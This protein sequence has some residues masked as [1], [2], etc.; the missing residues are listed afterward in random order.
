MEG[1]DPIK[2]SGGQITTCFVSRVNDWVL[3]PDITGTYWIVLG[4]WWRS[5]D[6]NT[7]VFGTSLWLLWRDWG[8]VSGEWRQ[9]TGFYLVVLFLFS[10]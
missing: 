6:M 1:E 7:Y 10:K 4:R 5:S 8:G 2:V 3:W 9:K